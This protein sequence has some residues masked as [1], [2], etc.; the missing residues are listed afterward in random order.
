MERI[1]EN[2]KGIGRLLNINNTNEDIDVE[3][4]IV[5]SQVFI[6]PDTHDGLS[7]I[8][9][10]KKFNGELIYLN[11]NIGIHLGN[12]TLEDSNGKTYKI[13]ITRYDLQTR[14]AF[15]SKAG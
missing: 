2:M 5:V 8:P 13:V 6:N 4:E 7:E 10:I 1:I 15:F 12:Q 11:E 14:R 9:G 3:Y